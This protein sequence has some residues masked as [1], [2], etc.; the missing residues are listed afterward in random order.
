M[1]ADA[2][3][4][5]RNR[6]RRRL[7]PARRRGSYRAWLKTQEETQRAAAPEIPDTGSIVLGEGGCD[8]T[9]RV[10]ETPF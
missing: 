5:Q 8:E 1:R 6:L 3:D 10:P 4:G 2:S 7:G 9:Y